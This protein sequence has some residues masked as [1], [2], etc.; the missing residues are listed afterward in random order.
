MD[1][2]G[3][4]PKFDLEPCAEADLVRCAALGDRAAFGKL[5]EPHY[6]TAYR[7]A[8]RVAGSRQNAEDAV[9]S[10]CVRMMS[11]LHTLKSA[12]SF[13]AWMVRVAINEALQSRRKNQR[14]QSMPDSYWESHSADLSSPE[15]LTTSRQLL[16]VI[17]EQLRDDG[18]LFVRRYL[19]G[20]TYRSLS[21]ET[22]VSQSALKTRLHRARD[23]IRTDF[24]RV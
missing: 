20:Q 7:A 9:Q 11:K 22:G 6:P 8:L 5:I 3:Q 16:S 14:L 17:G 4:N 2:R 12:S 24:A 18:V 15:H 19:L 10:A 21:H 23:R 1:C 13:S